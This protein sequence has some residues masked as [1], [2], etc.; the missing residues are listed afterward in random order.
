MKTCGRRRVPRRSPS[1]EGWEPSEGSHLEDLATRLLGTLAAGASAC[2][3]HELAGPFPR[4]FANRRPTT[5]STCIATCSTD[6]ICR[7]PV[8]SNGSRTCPGSGR[9][10]AAPVR[11]GDPDA[12]ADRRRRDQR[13]R[14]HAAAAIARRQ[15]QPADRAGAPDG[16]V[17]VAIGGQLTWAATSRSRSTTSCRCWTWFTRFRFEIA[18]ELARTYSTVDLFTPA[19]V[20]MTS[21]PAPT[22]P[23]R[24]SARSWSCRR[25]SRS[26][27]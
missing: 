14:H 15:G 16:A 25:W 2:A 19:M 21:G 8:S 11:K 22:F 23:R 20:A 26:F 4:R 27:R 17:A 10:R 9:L 1:R 6:R 3:H 7:S 24:R 5:P 13:A 18:A 12:D